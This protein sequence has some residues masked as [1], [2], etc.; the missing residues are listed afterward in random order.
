MDVLAQPGARY[1][2]AQVAFHLSSKLDQAMLAGDRGAFGF[3]WHDYDDCL[4][5]RIHVDRVMSVYR[6]SCRKLP[7]DWTNIC[8]THDKGDCGGLVLNFTFVSLPDNSGFVAVPQVGGAGGAGLGGMWTEGFRAPRLVYSSVGDPLAWSYFG[9]SLPKNA[10]LFNDFDDVLG[11]T[12][13]TIH[14]SPD[15][16]NSCPHA[17]VGQVDKAFDDGDGDAEAVGFVPV[18]YR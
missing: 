1:V 11:T 10:M 15:R 17:V 13:G 6:D 4:E 12:P 9:C 14:Q 16:R 2:L 7:A 5:D 3:E 18:K 8:L